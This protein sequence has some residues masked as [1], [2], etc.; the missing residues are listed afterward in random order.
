MY[1]WNHAW[2]TFYPTVGIFYATLTT[3]THDQGRESVKT[4]SAII[5]QMY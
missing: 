5:L 2:L 3:A 4:L 1:T